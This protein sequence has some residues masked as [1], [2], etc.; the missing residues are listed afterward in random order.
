MS[1][2][3]S[4][5]TPST[6][7]SAGA[8]PTA[9]QAAGAPATGTAPQSSSAPGAS[10]PSGV[11]TFAPLVDP[12]E[13]TLIPV[14]VLSVGGQASMAALAAASDRPGAQIVNGTVVAVTSAGRPLVATPIGLLSLDAQAGVPRETPVRLEVLP[15]TQAAAA[16]AS[17]PAPLLSLSREWPSLEEA[18]KTIQLA[19][20]EA[21]SQAAQTAVARPGPQLTAAMA[22]LFAAIRGGDIR[23]LLGNDA[24]RALERVRGGLAGTLREE[25]S[26]L[27]R[28][29][30]PS[31]GG[32]RAFFLPFSDGDTMQ[33]LGFWI[34]QDAQQGGGEDG[35]G[36]GSH[37]VVTLALSQL[38]DLRMDGRVEKKH[39]DLLL[40]TS[41]AMPK[42]MRDEIMTLFTGTL[43]RTGVTG[44]LRFQAGGAFPSLPIEH[45]HGYE[46][47][48]TDAV[49]V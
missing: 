9:A 35:D 17:P 38:G 45:L 24:T 33:Q 13:G 16:G 48:R 41:R 23:S 14:R 43:E 6:G 47:R 34:H 3:A 1:A 7:A 32:W 27:Q 12:R 40:R 44:R 42:D 8:Q 36:K 28:A 2:S 31:D 19:A 30:E 10:A 15:R 39:V 20:P 21:A 46:D 18:L 5:A 37:F 25:M 29:T 49:D 4:S 11:A 26:T 22:F